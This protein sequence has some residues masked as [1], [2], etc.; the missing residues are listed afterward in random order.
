MPRRRSWLRT[1]VETAT[2]PQ[3]G[4]RIMTWKTDSEWRPPADVPEPPAPSEEP[5]GP[6]EVPSPTPQEA[7]PVHD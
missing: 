3:Q 2:P 5:P 7:P 4:D 6:S 1:D